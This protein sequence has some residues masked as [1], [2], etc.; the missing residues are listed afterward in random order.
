MYHSI[1]ALNTVKFIF[2]CPEFIQKAADTDEILQRRQ[3]ISKD[4]KAVKK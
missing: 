3:K 1:T 4:P 2:S